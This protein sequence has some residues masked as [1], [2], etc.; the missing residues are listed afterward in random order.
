MRDAKIARFRLTFAY[1]AI[2]IFILWAL[3]YTGYLFHLNL[4]TAG[5]FCLIVVVLLSSFG[6]MISAALHSVVAVSCLDYF[7]ARRFYL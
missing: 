2:G 7:F 1:S 5:F 3:T 4:A 6:N